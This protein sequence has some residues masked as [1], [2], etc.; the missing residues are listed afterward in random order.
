ML[1]ILGAGPAGLAMA[2]A[3][4]KFGLRC[5]VVDRYGDPDQGRGGL[6]ITP[7]GMTVLRAL[8]VADH[9]LAGAAVAAERI[10]LADLATSRPI[11][12]LAIAHLAAPRAMDYIL[13][14]RSA[15]I[16]C[17]RDAVID[18]GIE[19]ITGCDIEVLEPSSDCVA[20]Q[21]ADGRQG[22]ADAVIGA[23]GVNS[24]TRRAISADRSRARP[25]YRVW[26]TVIAGAG[27]NS[28]IQ[29]G[30]IMLHV[31]R[32]RHLVRYRVGADGHVNTVA[33][34]AIRG[35]EGMSD[36]PPRWL[37]RLLPVTKADYLDPAGLVHSLARVAL[38][39]EAWYNDRMVLIGDA[40][41][42]MLPFLAQGANMA[43][44]DA[45]V[46]ARS[47]A[48]AQRITAGFE[49]Y[50]QFRT[51]RIESVIRFSNHQAAINHHFL[52]YIGHAGAAGLRLLNTVFPGLIAR[53]YQWILNH[54][55]TRM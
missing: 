31:G 1:L 38:H 51:K 55:V 19:I 6:Q 50:R 43:L 33:V 12:D 14:R 25:R 34:E 39:R 26:R 16:T 27:G 5:Q 41:H 52:P 32:G 3:C 11:C 40:L 7:N 30:R 35:E 45:Y 15:L 36:T 29:P 4:R 48:R 21:A 10:S 24:V 46:L 23:D 22:R 42:P 17:L 9:R 2:L 53:R 49:Q 20:W 18:A 44:E 54:D 47:I 13:L 8:G 28:S 37:T